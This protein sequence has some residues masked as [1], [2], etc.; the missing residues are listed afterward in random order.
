MQSLRRDYKPASATA[1]TRTCRMECILRFAAAINQLPPANLGF[2]KGRWPSLSTSAPHRF[3]HQTVS[4]RGMTLSEAALKNT[5]ALHLFQ[6]RTFNGVYILCSY[7]YPQWTEI[8]IFG[9]RFGSVQVR[10]F[11]VFLA[12]LV[13]FCIFH[14][15][16]ETFLAFLGICLICWLKII[17][18]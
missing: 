18:A 2:V 8:E 1:P 10:Y 6:R 7:A 4:G 15:F 12:F 17:V 13:I 14:K 11:S 16:R 9:Q 3:P 5:L